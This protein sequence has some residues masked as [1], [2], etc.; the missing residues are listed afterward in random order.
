MNDRSPSRVS[1]FLVDDHLL[2]RQGL[3]LL[4]E[5]AGFAIAGAA[6]N[7]ASTLAHPGL[8]AAQVV[9]LD[10]GLGP[11]SG[12]ELIPALCQRGLP[13]VVYSMH[14][15]VTVVRRTLAAGAAAYVT[16]GE[17]AHS[18]VE[19]IRTVLAGRLYLSPSAADALVTHP[20]RRV[21]NNGNSG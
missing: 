9:V 2:V 4:L 3:A 19:A 11:A 18:L 10:L 8:A 17:A 21:G 20:D 14:D 12:L 16:K 6:A 7:A 15:E 5:Q 1:V 13:V